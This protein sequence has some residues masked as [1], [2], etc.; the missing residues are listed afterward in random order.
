MVITPPDAEGAL[1]Y[2]SLQRGLQILALVQEQGRLRIADISERLGMPLSTVYRYVSALAGSG[3]A[4][5]I[6]GYLVAGERLAEE[7]DGPPHLVSVAAPILH[8]LR[9]DTG[10]TAILAVRVHTVAVSLEVSL[11]HPQHRV[12][13]GRGR[14][15]SLYAGASALPLLA[16]APSRIVRDLL[17]AELRPFTNATLAPEMIEPYLRQIRSDGYAVTRGQ[18]TPGMIGVGVPVLIGEA[19]LCSISLVG[20]ESQLSGEL[21]VA[22]AALR[23]A[24]SELVH[25]LPTERE[26][27]AWLSA[28]EQ[29]G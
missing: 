10:M 14:V 22:V 3:F 9:L 18:I 29:P 20:E 12:S 13:F 17:S 8:R 4:H 15:R 2:R 11:A 24:A 16:Y 1:G 7:H 28:G 5:E 25:R 27:D 19:C 6:D 21:G 23:T 26:A